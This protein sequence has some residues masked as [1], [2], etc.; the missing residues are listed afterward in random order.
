[1]PDLLLLTYAVLFFNSP[2]VNFD[3]LPMSDRDPWPKNT[4]KKKANIIYES[5]YKMHWSVLIC[6]IQQKIAELLEARLHSGPFSDFSFELC[7]SQIAPIFLSCVGSFNSTFQVMAKELS[8]YPI[9][10]I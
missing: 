10:S 6:I 2:L 1:M 5:E 4:K 9:V 3:R 7:I 8:Y